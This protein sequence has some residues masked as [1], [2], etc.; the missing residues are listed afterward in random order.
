MKV[1]RIAIKSYLINKVLQTVKARWTQDRRHKTIWI[2]SDNDRTHILVNDEEFALSVAQTGF[3]IC[4]INQP[5]NSLD[6]NVLDIRFF[7]SL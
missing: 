6:M 5:P 3:D 1:K 2:Q 7:A 4:L